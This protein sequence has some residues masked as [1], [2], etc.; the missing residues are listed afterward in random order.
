MG[1]DPRILELGRAGESARASR[2]FVQDWVRDA[3]V[4]QRSRLEWLD[5][6]AAERGLVTRGTIEPDQQQ[7]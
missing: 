4:T 6:Q 7:D 2:E 5:R 1:E 3:E